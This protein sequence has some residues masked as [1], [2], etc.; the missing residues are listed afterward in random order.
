MPVAR[1]WA[2]ALI[3]LDGTLIEVEADISAQLPAFVIIGLGDRSLR[4]AEG[5]VRQAVSNSGCRLAARRITVNLSPASLPK[6]GAG[7]DLAIALACLAAD[8]VIDRASVDQVVHIGELG[9][10]GRLRPTPGVL[11]AVRA[12]VREGRSTVMV[13]V[14]NADEARLVPG[15]DII[16]VPSLRDAA[17][18]HGADLAARPVEAITAPPV[19]DVEP[20]SLDIAD[21]IGQSDAVDALE[22]AAAG[23]HHLMMLGPPGSG[24]TMIAERLPGILPDLSIDEALE[25][26]SVGSLAGQPFGGALRLRPG[27]EAPHH[28]ATAA[29]IIGGGSGTIRPG[30]AA[31]AVNGVLFL[32][33]APEFD[34]T[35]LDALRQPLE[36]GIITIHRAHAVAR[37]P[38]RFQL[39]IAA[40]PCPCGQYG[41]A[42]GHCTCPPASIR[43]YLGR[44]SGP[45][46][47]RVDIQLSVSRVS[48]A[49][50]QASASVD[51]PRSSDV[52]ARVTEARARAAER[53]RSTPWTRNSE[54]TGAW[55]RGDGAVPRSVTAGID[56][57]LERGS[58]TMRGYDRVLRVAWTISDLAGTEQPTAEHVGKA[59]YLRKGMTP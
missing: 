35:V 54:V 45:L 9:L 10:D 53:L 36:S 34:R 31:R 30:A 33:E 50:L 6:H 16:A 1:T 27:Y 19:P 13:P 7:F 20:E 12:A 15:A 29:A 46:R 2:L 14:A 57:A 55:L 4:E 40:N 5:R 17:I 37:F 8:G 21:V 28:T 26:A 47:D 41:A 39:V 22:T 49:H 51:R 48:A 42:D 58:L 3:G 56:R 43:R 44:L 23:G 11:P 59:L 24:K 52:R 32:D 38:G 25:T 18:H